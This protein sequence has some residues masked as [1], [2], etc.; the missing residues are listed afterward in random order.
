MARVDF[1]YPS[2][3]LAIEVDGAQFH[4][5]SEAQER[6][7]RRQDEIEAL[8]WRVLRFTARDLRHRR[9]WVLR[10]LGAALRS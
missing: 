7:R 2:S 4:T 8:G 6:D 5:L 9:E 1:A 10:V 3:R